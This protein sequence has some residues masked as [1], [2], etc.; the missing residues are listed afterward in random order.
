MD[1]A[2]NNGGGTVLDTDVEFSFAYAVSVKCLWDTQGR[3][4]GGS[5]VEKSGV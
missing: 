5:Y 2:R 3:E 4:G 1:W